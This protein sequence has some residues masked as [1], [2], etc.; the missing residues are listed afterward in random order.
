[1]N[2]VSVPRGFLRFSEAISRLEEGMWGG[3]P[4]ADSVRN[5]KRTFKRASIGFGPWREKAGQRLTAA[6][7]RGKLVV[8]VLLK[9]RAPFTNRSLAR[10]SQ[11]KIEP[12]PVSVLR[13]LIAPRKSLPDHPI[14]PSIMTAEGNEKL[15]AFLTSGFLVVRA[16]DFD[17][18][19]R[20]ERA[21]CKWPSQQGGRGRLGQM[22]PIN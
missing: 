1:M 10:R 20:S 9:P 21:K 19:Y 2:D 16:N 7:R 11:E 4:Q 3:L 18:W 14:R 6:V 22:R 13:R 8:Y 12:V 15:L 5:I 17:A